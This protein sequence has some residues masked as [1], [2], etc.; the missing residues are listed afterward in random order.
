MKDSRFNCSLIL[1]LYPTEASPR[2][3]TTL[4]RRK[5]SKFI[6]LAA[7]SRPLGIET[8]LMKT[9]P[10]QVASFSI[11]KDLSFKPWKCGGHFFEFFFSL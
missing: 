1:Y 4:N 7:S 9:D 11:A 5:F 2:V 3:N 10:N 8:T 6:H